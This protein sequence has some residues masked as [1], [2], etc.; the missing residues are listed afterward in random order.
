MTAQPTV[1][2]GG[3]AT[4]Q[5]RVAVHVPFSYFDQSVSLLD[6]RITVVENF[7]RLNPSVGEQ[8]CRASLARFQFKA[9]AADRQVATLSGGQLLR[10]G[11]A[12]VL[13]GARPPSLLILDE[14][15][16]HLDMES[17]AAV[18]AGLRAFD[19][20]LL[21]VSHDEMFLD[22]VG[23]TRRINIARE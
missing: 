15:T 2:A 3:L 16:N 9:D 5:G 11:V 6:P 7:S 12:C 20:A 4:W 22:A 21:I 23:I 13:G 14:P 1:R 19:G 18:E 8:D 17:I 10:A